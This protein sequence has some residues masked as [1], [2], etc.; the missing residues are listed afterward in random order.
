MGLN[1]FNAVKE[2]VSFESVARDYGLE[3]GR[4]RKASCP[5]HDEGKSSFHDYGDHGH[6]FGCGGHADIIGLEA[7]FK[8]L[9]PF[10]A[11]QSLAERYSVQLPSFTP[12]DKE[13]ADQQV[14]AYEL[15]HRLAVYANK[16]VKGYLEALGFLERKGLGTEDIDRW[17]I[18]YVGTENPVINK[19]KDEPDAMELA[20][21]IEL[22]KGHSDYFRNR[23][24][25][26]VW[27]Y[28]KIVFLTGRQF[29]NG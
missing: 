12:R 16:K 22:I 20:R 21:E 26:P 1:I 25:I 2:R 28:G 24:I 27:N 17:L 18:G 29:P 15:L 6:C 5:F 8:N 10:E 14:K 9:P 4:D 11:A 7:H 3:F 23:I 13:R 19:L